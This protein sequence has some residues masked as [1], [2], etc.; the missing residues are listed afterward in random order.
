M[1]KLHNPELVVRE[2]LRFPNSS[3]SRPRRPRFE[4]LSS[5]A[6]KLMQLDSARPRSAS[7]TRAVSA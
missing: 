3:H 4:V 5:K 1:E 6:N 2:A 7:W